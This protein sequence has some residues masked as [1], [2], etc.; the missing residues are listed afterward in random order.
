MRSAA[1]LAALLDGNAALFREDQGH[2]GGEPCTVS[3]GERRARSDKQGDI[4]VRHPSTLPGNV[5][6]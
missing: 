4:R 6:E 3:L 2:G 5:G 1:A